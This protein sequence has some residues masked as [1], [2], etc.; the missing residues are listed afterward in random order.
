[1]EIDSIARNQ[2][3]EKLHKIISRNF[4]LVFVVDWELAKSA[5]TFLLQ[6]R[7]KGSISFG[8]R[9]EHNLYNF[10]QPKWMWTDQAEAL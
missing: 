8:L 1:M 6:L 9:I 3:K 5:N 4:K 2:R 10:M 7:A